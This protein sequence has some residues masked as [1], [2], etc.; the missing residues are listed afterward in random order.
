MTQFAKEEVRQAILAAAREEFSR[1]GFEKASIRTIAANAKTA[2]SNLYN[3]YADKDALFQAVVGETVAG[4]RRGLEAAREESANETAENYSMGSQE[5][6]MRAVMLFVAAHTQDVSLLLFRSAG[7]SL[8]G[9]REEVVE[10][11]TGLLADWFAA[12][13]PDRGPSRL[14]LRCVASFYVTAV[15]RI[16]LERPPRERAEAYLGEF[17]RF[18]YGG[19]STL[20]NS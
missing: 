3:Y 19:W 6:Y 13:A 4:I 7:S 1:Q 8:E 9:L 20:M 2:K 18:A 10:G 15:E 16:L 12:A 17:L 11:F 5:R 14:F